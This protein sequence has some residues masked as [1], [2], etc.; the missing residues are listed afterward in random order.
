MSKTKE[1]NVMIDWKKEDENRGS[2][3][4]LTDLDIEKGYK[5]VN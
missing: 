3:T 5:E 2:Q 4:L 1:F